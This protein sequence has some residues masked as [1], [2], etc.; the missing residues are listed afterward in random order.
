M[1]DFLVDHAIRNIWCTPNQDRQ[2]IIEPAKISPFDG[3]LNSVVV[4]NR[5]I[6]LPISGV[7]FHVYQIGRIYPSTL[8]IPQLTNS[9]TTLA[10]ACNNSKL[11]VDIYTN[12][13]LQLPRVH[14]WYMITPDNNLILA[15]RNQP[16][17]NVDLNIDA[18]FLR[19]YTNAFFSSS[20]ADPVNDYIEVQGGDLLSVNDIISLQM[21]YNAISSLPGAT[22]AFI[23]GKKASSIDLISMQ[24]GDVAEYVYDSS[25]S[26][27]I[28]I[29]INEMQTFIST[30]DSKNKYLVHYS[31][32]DNKIEYL[33]DVDFFLIQPTSVGRHIGVYYHKN[34]VDAVRMVTHKDY[35]IV[36]PYLVGYL[37]SVSGWTDVTKLTLR[38]HIRKSGYNR[39]LVLENN[40]IEELYKL[41]DDKLIQAMVGVNSTVP[42]WTAA[43]LENSPYVKL[44]GSNY[45][46]ITKNLVESAYGYNLISTVV[47]HTPEI[48]DNGN[49]MP[50]VNVPYGLISKSV[51]YEYDINGLL[52]G[53]YQHISSTKYVAINTNCI[54]VEFIAGYVNSSL[55]LDEVYGGNNIAIDSTAEY[56]FYMCPIINGLPTNMW[57]DVTN[58]EHYDI[59]NNTVVWN[60]NHKQYYTLVRSNKNILAY[61][62]MLIA[63]NGLINF[64]IVHNQIRNNLDSMWVMQIP[65]GELDIFLNGH[66]LIEGIDYIYNFPEI[67]I[68]SKKFLNDILNTPQKITVRY[69]GF[70]NN[71]FTSDVIPD[72]GF[73]KYNLLSYNDHFNIRDDKVLRVVVNGGYYSTHQLLFTESDSGIIGPSIENG[74]PFSIRD[75]IVPLRGI[76]IDNTYI[77]RSKSLIID[78][79][80]S[81]YMS[82]FLPQ[83]DLT[84]P[85]IIES[86]YPVYSPFICKI[87][88]DLNSGELSDPRILNQYSDIDVKDICAPYEYLLAFDP[89]IPA[90]NLDNNYVII[91]PHNLDT[92]I[93]VNIYQ[94]KFIDNVIRLYANGLVST[95]GFL[96]ITS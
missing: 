16:K 42:N 9:W 96:S 26:K 73:V 71:D 35:S 77:A 24:P 48:I 53:W 95:I 5:T 90:N 11:I 27:V 6:A 4:I 60:V 14:V 36:V 38:L 1:Y 47:G 54:Q 92:V 19:V 67:V 25:I 75:I 59:I 30:L 40:R 7:R 22:Y 21:K 28:D 51:A 18:I 10:T 3:L 83:I 93:N 66:S 31:G 57:E 39:T 91:H 56:R 80:I 87:I 65:M 37:N 13:G 41:S 55:E 62:I 68:I 58:S 64:S 94:Y 29:P 81:N 86:L 69:T 74:M 82:S 79:L 45:V 2:V 33:D 50:L 12:S 23:N 84:D 32:A 34:M 46:G 76:G 63:D 72:T 70:C 17:I 88:Y 8:G 52:L 49:G 20:E 61:D 44:M 85:N 78:N 15:V 43:N 89:I